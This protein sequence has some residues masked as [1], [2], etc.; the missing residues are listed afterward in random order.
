MEFRRPRPQRST[1][2]LASAMEMVQ[3]DNIIVMDK[4]GGM[5]KHL[6]PE[7]RR[8]LMEWLNQQE[9]SKVPIDIKGNQFTVTMQLE[10]DEQEALAVGEEDG[11]KAAKKTTKGKLECEP[12]GGYH[13]GMGRFGALRRNDCC[14]VP[15]LEDPDSDGDMGFVGRDW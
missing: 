13:I 1:K 9:G 3:A 7:K 10:Q 2:P 6:S 14:N 15:A 5:I 8:E 12:C 11:F 4:E